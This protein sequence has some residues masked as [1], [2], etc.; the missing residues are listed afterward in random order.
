MCS[1][2]EKELCVETTHHLECGH[3]FHIT[4][5]CNWFRRG[6]SVCPTCRHT[7]NVSSLTFPD[8]FARAKILRRHARSKIAPKQLRYLVDILKKEEVRYRKHLEKLREFTSTHAQM[9]THY[10]KLTNQQHCI[11]RK[12]TAHTRTLGVFSSAEFP[13][14]HIFPNRSE[15]ASSRPSS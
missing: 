15:V 9:L 6:I 10:R 1:I 14:P 5:I 4:C 11:K 3:S 13:L 2:C 12:I 8:S 7:D